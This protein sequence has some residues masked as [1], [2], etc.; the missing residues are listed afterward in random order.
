[1]GYIDVQ[2][3]LNLRA[4]VIGSGLSKVISG[5]VGSAPGQY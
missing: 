1:M 4:F 3:K 5:V 2:M